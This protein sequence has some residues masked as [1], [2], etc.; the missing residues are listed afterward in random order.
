M[1][2]AP[3][4]EVLAAICI[5]DFLSSGVS[6]KASALKNVSPISAVNSSFNFLSEASSITLETLLPK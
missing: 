1:I 6:I 3:L 4:I 5:E 2:K